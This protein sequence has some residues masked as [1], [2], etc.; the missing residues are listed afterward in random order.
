ME[1]VVNSQLY[2]YSAEGAVDYAQMNECRIH[3]SDCVSTK[4]YF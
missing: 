4:Q 2:Y 1:S 3:I